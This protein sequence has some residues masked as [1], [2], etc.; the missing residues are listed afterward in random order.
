MS[1]RGEIA[2]G[3]GVKFFNWSLDS[4]FVARRVSTGVFRRSGCCA[5]AVAR[6]KSGV[7]NRTNCL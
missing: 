5:T 3:A 1:G 4:S 6:G 7:I 2:L